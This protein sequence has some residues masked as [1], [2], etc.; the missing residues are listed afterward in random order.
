MPVSLFQSR[1]WMSVAMLWA[2]GWR[3]T[4]HMRGWAKEASPFAA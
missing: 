3:A 4:L 2:P 1:R